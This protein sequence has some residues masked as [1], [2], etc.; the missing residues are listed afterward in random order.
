MTPPDTISFLRRISAFAVLD[1][2]ELE[3]VAGQLEVEHFRIGQVICREGEPGD[4]LYVVYSGRARVLTVA[5]GVETT[6]GT[7]ARGD[8][9]GEQALL[10][11]GARAYTVRAAEDLVLQRMRQDTFQQVLAER[12]ELRRYFEQHLADLATRNFLRMC[13]WLRALRAA[14]I[15]AILRHLEQREFPA[16]AQVFE[17][18]DAGDRFYL[19]RT[20]RA[21]VRQND[22]E[23][24]RLSEGQ[25]FGELALLT[26][27]PR[28][29]TVT[30]GTDLDTLTLSSEK[31]SDLIRECP[32]LRLSIEAIAYSY[33]AT[34]PPESRPTV[35]ADDPE[36]A[37]LYEPESSGAASLAPQRR[38][39]RSWPVILQIGE[40]DCGAACLAMVGKHYGRSYQI[41]VL[42]EMAGI[43]REGSSLRSLADTAEKLGFQAR[44]VRAEL[45][46]LANATLPCVAHWGG[47]HFVVVYEI[48]K[49]RVTVA[50][51]ALGLLRMTE[52]EFRRG[53]TGM[54]LLLE[55]V[56]TLAPSDEAPSLLRRFMPLVTPYWPMLAEVL[57]CSLIL[58]VLGL[59]TPL[60]TQVIVDRVIV[61]REISTLN[62]MLMGMMGVVL[63]QVLA[64]AL[65]QSLLVYTVRR[66]DVSISVQF[67]SHILRL[68]TRYFENTRV[69]DVVTRFDETQH[70]RELLTGTALTALLD[71]MTVVVF[72]LVMLAY[73]PQLTLVILVSIPLFALLSL[74]LTPMLRSNFRKTFEAHCAAQ[75][76]L[77]ETISGVQVVKSAC[78]EQPVRWKWEELLLR[79]IRLQFQAMNYRLLLQSI[80]TIMQVSV[81]TALLWFG[82]RL[83]IGNQLTVGQL[84]AFM[85]MSGTLMA[86]MLGIVRVWDEVQNARLSLERLSDVFDTKPEESSGE[87]APPPLPAVRG[88]IKFEKLTFRYDERARANALENIDLEFLPGQTVAVVGRSGCG[89]STLIKLLM[90][91]YEPNSGRITVDGQD[92]CRVSAASWRRQ[93]GWVSQESFLF[94]GSIR[95]NIALGDPHASLEDVQKAAL[96][97]GAHDFI[98]DLPL[99]YNTLVGE[100]GASL[101]GGQRQR[102]NIARA[103]LMDPRVLIMDEATSALDTESE[104]AIQR[105]METVLQNRT[106]LVIAH[107]L[108]TIRSAHKIVV[109][110]R[111]ILIEQGT[112]EELMA[113]RGLYFYL[114]SQQLEQ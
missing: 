74:T 24:A 55:P 16:G 77:V 73:N 25:F 20:G 113:R 68:P 1:D 18:G 87:I 93:V 13:G 65:R 22:V 11:G 3:R 79:Y 44:P 69:G 7:L 86:S 41:P 102:V 81:S 27:E 104:R 71:V 84:M 35:R 98:S 6:V 114:C 28:A 9:F 100:R 63:F 62:L 89:K 26:G 82:A 90:R 19:I 39:G 47:N 109:M 107:R 66:I 8:H 97:A 37:P 54:A 56:A 60:F 32:G 40:M 112:H 29:A 36:P 2:E 33:Q 58:Q 96:L 103:L 50:D 49:G 72:S 101:S 75:S 111:G 5:E 12:P 78:A 95:E 94:S 45:R 30:A 67:L 88:H 31:F 105:S 92:L 108:S 23:I 99:G 14:E 57:V 43:T 21:L 51:P 106:T 52:A 46:H 61:H 64:T 83:V 17:Q 76:H 110:D 85:A 59:A 70:V 80:G 38:R 34:P 42:R 10:E 48:K 15:Q 53:W 91:L 4:S